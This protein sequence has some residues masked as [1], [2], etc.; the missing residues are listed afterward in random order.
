MAHTLTPT[1]TLFSIVVRTLQDIVALCTAPARAGNDDVA[2][3]FVLERT[4]TTGHW[5][6]PAA[7]STVG[8]L[9]VRDLPT[10]EWESTSERACEREG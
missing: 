2:P 4:L 8:G 7:L 9:L 3:A 10:I 5:T 6:L 1:L